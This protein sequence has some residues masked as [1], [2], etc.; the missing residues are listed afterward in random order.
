M[1]FQRTLKKEI[2]G[3]GIGL[4][5]G[6]KVK[7]VLKPAP[8]DHGIKFMHINNGRQT[9]IDATAEN[10]VATN[11]ATSLGKDGE[12][13]GTVE[14]LLAAFYGLGVDN[15]LVEVHGNE[16][17]I[18]DGSAIPFV[19]LIKT[20]GIVFQKVSKK[21]LVLKEKM[22]VSEDD[23]KIV[24]EPNRFLSVSCFIDFHHPLLKKQQCSFQFSDVN[25]E[26][27]I[28]RAR[29]FGFLQ[30]VQM[31]KSHGLARGGSLENAVVLDEFGVMNEGGLR[32]H[33]ECARHKVLDC[34][35]DI[36]LLGMPLIAKVTAYKAGHT[37]NH[38][39]V[40]KV[41]QTPEAWEVVTPLHDQASARQLEYEIPSL[42][43]AEP[44]MMAS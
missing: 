24:L 31:L 21:F 38:Q 10:V 39:L 13:I 35:G 2:Y 20:A 6:N 15:A 17:P 25:F 41:L 8:A 16:I 19:F 18:M 26:R 44:Q 9:L 5:S 4:H 42:A 37:L 12:V 32:F 43:G 36:S 33:N 1:L 3:I 23:K 29:T 11:Y 27:Q 28:S 40:K 34:L 14:H 7:I 30:E 22:T